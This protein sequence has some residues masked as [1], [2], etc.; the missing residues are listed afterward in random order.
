MRGRLAV[1]RVRQPISI[2][3][4]LAIASFVLA[5]VVADRLFPLLSANNDEAVYLFQARIFRSG[6]L[7][8]PADGYRDFFR[9]WMSSE[10]DQ[11]LVLVFQPV[12]PALLALSDLV[13]GSMR[14][15]LGMIAGGSVLLVYALCGELGLSSRA[16]VIA[17]CALRAC[18]RSPSYRARSISSTSSPS[19]SRWPFSRCCWPGCD[20]PRVGGRDG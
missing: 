5:L 10:H 16:R 9:P 13:F 6:H 18:R 17:C 19:P 20:R 3:I 12:F 15:A 8:L 7:T 14:V 2:V 4:V 1:L 11:Q